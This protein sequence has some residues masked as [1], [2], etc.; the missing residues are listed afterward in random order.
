MIKAEIHSRNAQIV[1][2]ELTGHAD[3]A[4]YGSD[5]VCAGVS[6][7]VIT[8]VNSIELL[9]GYSPIVEADEENGGYVY[10]EVPEGITEEQA[11]VTQLLL[12]SFRIGMQGIADEYEDY[13]TL[14]L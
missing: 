9:A 7:L 5:I 11:S 4:E 8:A 6:A 1:S 3:F 10:L 13:I 12:S 2:F 14:T